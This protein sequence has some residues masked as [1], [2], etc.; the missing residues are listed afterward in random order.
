MA[1]TV[2]SEPTSAILTVS[3][4]SP[5]RRQSFCEGRAGRKAVLLLPTQLQMSCATLSVSEQSSVQLLA[6]LAVWEKTELFEEEREDRD[7]YRL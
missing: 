2:L 3:C 5:Q 4:G 6:R 1:A 7:W